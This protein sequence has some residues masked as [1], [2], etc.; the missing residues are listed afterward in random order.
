MTKEL[1]MDERRELVPMTPE[2]RISNIETSLDLLGRMPKEQLG[3]ALK[4]L[5]ATGFDTVTLS[6][7]LMSL[8]REASSLMVDQ[9]MINI[10]SFFIY[11]F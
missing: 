8:V 6:K 1:V 3:E 11:L 9:K 2:E 5:E 4:N 10:I 7:S